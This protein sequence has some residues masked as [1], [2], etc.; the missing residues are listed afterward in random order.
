MKTRVNIRFVV[1]LLGSLAVLGTATHF[2]HGYQVKRSAGALFTRAT[3]AQERGELTEAANLYERYLGL[4]P[5]D[6]EALTKFGDLLAN[7]K[8]SKL[9]MAK[10]RAWLVL[11]KV[12]YRG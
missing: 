12:L 8:Y 10:Q 7:E 5:G 9:L 11:N 6:I 3:E 2:I 4:V 1:I